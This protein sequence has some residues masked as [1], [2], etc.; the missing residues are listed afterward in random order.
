MLLTR[1]TLVLTDVLKFS[2]ILINLCEQVIAKT[3]K[4]S[5]CTMNHCIAHKCVSEHSQVLQRQLGIT[6]NTTVQKEYCMAHSQNHDNC[7]SNC[8]KFKAYST[9]CYG[10]LYTW[11]LP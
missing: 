10:Q 2:G 8:F 9:D 7:G 11:A 3:K 6:G 5:L 4:H 1:N